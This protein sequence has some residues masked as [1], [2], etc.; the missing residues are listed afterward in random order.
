[1]DFLFHLL[2]FIATTPT[3]KAELAVGKVV[4][5]WV[6]WGLAYYASPEGKADAA[7][8]LTLAT[9]LEGAVHVPGPFTS[10]ITLPKTASRPETTYSYSTR[11]GIG[12]HL[13]APGT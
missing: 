10:T 6:K 12:G 9:D 8:I 4:L 5:K 3:E 13:M 2:E 1:M 7:V 11:D